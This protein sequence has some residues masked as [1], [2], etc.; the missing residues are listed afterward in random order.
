MFDLLMRVNVALLF[1]LGLMAMPV[2]ALAQDDAAASEEPG[3]EI[4][5]EDDLDALFGD[6]AEDDFLAELDEEDAEDAEAS[7]PESAPAAAVEETEA[8]PTAG[9]VMAEEAEEDRLVEEAEAGDVGRTVPA[10]EEQEQAQQDEPLAT[11]SDAEDMR[12]SLDEVVVTA[13]RRKQDIKEVP[14]SVVSLDGETMEEMDMTSLNDL[15]RAVPTLK[16]G[17]G[18]VFNAV[19]IR[20]LGSG[21]NW[22]VDQAVGIFVDDVYYTGAEKLSTSMMDI[23][24]IEILRGPQGTLFGRNTIAGALLINTGI[25]EHEWGGNA[26]VTFGEHERIEGNITLNAPIIEDYVAARGAFRWLEQQGHIYDRLMKERHKTEG[27]SFRG[28]FRYS[29]SDNLDMQ[30]EVFDQKGTSDGGTNVQYWNIQDEH[31]QLMKAFDPESESNL[32]DYHHSSNRFDGGTEWQRDYTARA[33]LT[34]WDTDFLV[35]GNYSDQKGVGGLDVD[36]GPIPMLFADG[37]S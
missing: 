8:D 14:V 13:Q 29:A 35:I 4:A 18:G 16:V 19:A 6:D 27:R 7:A 30:I 34:A 9:E 20:G 22:G 23:Q 31:L 5:E 33:R 10:P 36:Y 12:R 28:K 26:E 1:A 21:I 15:N 32:W 2:V 17:A 25:P 24:S 11:A 37:L 3:E